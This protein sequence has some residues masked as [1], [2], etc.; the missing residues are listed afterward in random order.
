MSVIIGNKKIDPWDIHSQ[1]AAKTLNEVNNV[2]DEIGEGIDNV[3]SSLHELQQTI[4]DLH[5]NMGESAETGTPLRLKLA[6]F[7]PESMLSGIGLVFGPGMVDGLMKIKEFD[8]DIESMKLVSRENDIPIVSRSLEKILEKARIGKFWAAVI[9]T[10][11]PVDTI[12]IR[13]S[14][15][16]TA[17]IEKIGR[18]R[19]LIED[20]E[21][22]DIDDCPDPNFL[23]LD[24]R[25]REFTLGTMVKDF[26]ND[27][28]DYFDP[29]FDK[30]EKMLETIDDHL[31]D[32]CDDKNKPFLTRFY[33]SVEKRFED[34]KKRT[35]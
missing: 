11:Y 3:R 29:D 16:I 22:I 31:D 33:E 15:T 19:L 17:R 8:L 30:V 1:H 18:R 27:P 32:T 13:F 23:D 2:L 6:D 24:L 28:M 21:G 34:L 35:D 7:L 12:I 10:V 14:E 25:T 5:R 20:I 9:K 4:V 26:T